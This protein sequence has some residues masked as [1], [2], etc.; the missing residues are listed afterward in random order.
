MM[1]DHWNAKNSRIMSSSPNLDRTEK[2]M[3]ENY[4]IWV[5][6]NTLEKIPDQWIR[7]TFTNL[8]VGFSILSTFLK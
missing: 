7:S 3:V 5:S 8:Q 4:A 6:T 2:R 1:E